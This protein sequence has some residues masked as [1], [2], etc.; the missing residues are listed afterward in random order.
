MESPKSLI[1]QRI[2]LKGRLKL[3]AQ[4]DAENIINQCCSETS[5][6]K[7]VAAS[8][9]HRLDTASVGASIIV[10]FS[11]VMENSTGQH[12]FEEMDWVYS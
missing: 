10:E 3:S 9:K 1:P 12:C 11:S 5:L 4:V 6:F 8:H 7:M 2:L